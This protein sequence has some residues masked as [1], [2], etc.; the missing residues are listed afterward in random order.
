MAAATSF[1]LASESTPGSR[2][3]M[4]SSN[5]TSR[6]SSYNASI[7]EES[8]APRKNATLDSISETGSFISMDKFMN[9]QAKSTS[10][11]RRQTVSNKLREWRSESHATWKRVQPYYEDFKYWVMMGPH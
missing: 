11:S 6:S 4:S 7:Q 9:E 10:S 8:A 3:Y 1:F 5:N 2:K